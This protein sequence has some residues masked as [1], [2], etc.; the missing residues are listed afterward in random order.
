MCI[1]HNAQDE[2]ESLLR[3]ERSYTYTHILGTCVIH[4]SFSKY[5]D[6]PLTAANETEAILLR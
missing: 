2:E 5:A 4:R 3:R 1:M 6:V